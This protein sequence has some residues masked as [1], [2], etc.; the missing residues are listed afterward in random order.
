MLFNIESESDATLQDL[1]PKPDQ[2]KSDDDDS[3]PEEPPIVVHVLSDPTEPTGHRRPAVEYDVDDDPD[4][5]VGSVQGITLGSNSHDLDM[6][7]MPP[8]DTNEMNEGVEAVAEKRHNP[9]MDASKGGENG[10]VLL[11][12]TVLSAVAPVALLLLFS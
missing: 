9:K 4:V 12:L 6:S 5:G 8:L 11:R 7:D 1:L 3:V 10:A 2:P